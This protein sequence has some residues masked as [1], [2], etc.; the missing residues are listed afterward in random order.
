MKYLSL[1]AGFFLFAVAADAHSQADDAQTIFNPQGSTLF[2]LEVR[3]MAWADID[4]DGDTDVVLAHRDN[5]QSLLTVYRND[6]DR[7]FV[8]TVV[9]ELPEDVFR[10]SAGELRRILLEDIDGDRYPDLL[11][12]RFRGPNSIHRNNGRG[13]FEG[14]G[15]MLGLQVDD[16]Y[17]IAGLD[18]DGDGDRDLI[19]SNMGRTR[20]YLNDGDGNFSAGR[21]I[22]REGLRGTA[23]AAG[24]FDGDG[25]DDLV[26]GT[27]EK[28]IF[29]FENYGDGSFD[30]DGA[31]ITAG[32]GAFSTFQFAVVDADNDGDLDILAAGTVL[33]FFRNK[34]DGNF[35]AEIALEGESYVLPGDLD[36]DGDLDIVTGYTRVLLNNGNGEWTSS[37]WVN[38]RAG[39]REVSLQ[40]VDNDGDL[41]LVAIRSVGRGVA[42]YLNDT[43]PGEV[44]D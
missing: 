17:T 39:A 25:D 16:T 41:D 22:N 19:V 20:R 31:K 14:A 36:L 21:S 37:G 34:G 26:L 11:I 27:R 38:R 18:A 7:E 35:G 3:H 29:V 42:L 28:D 24:D 8:A 9:F 23:V 1:A 5:R 4:L 44:A 30:A 43:N 6:G 40:D 12:A 32:S 13:G 33:G 2:P 10:D 15:V